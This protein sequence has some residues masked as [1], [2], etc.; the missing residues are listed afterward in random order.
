MKEERRDLNEVEEKH[1]DQ[2]DHE[3]TGEKSASCSKTENSCSQSNIQITEVKRPF[4]CCECGN[5]FKHKRSLMYHTLVH[6]GIK[7]FTCSE[8]GKSFTQKKTTH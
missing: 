3:I 7:P 4:T 2:K 5:T 6:A 1:Q 8:C